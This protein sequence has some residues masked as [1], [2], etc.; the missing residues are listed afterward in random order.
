MKKNMSK[1]KIFSLIKTPCGRA[2][3]SE[4]SLKTNLFAKLRLYWFIFF[5]IIKDWNLPNPDQT[6][7]SIS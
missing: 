7:D 5:A 6:E 4:L 1:P 2:K 3:Y